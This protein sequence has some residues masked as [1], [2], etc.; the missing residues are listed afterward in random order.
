MEKRIDNISKIY[1]NGIQMVKNTVIFSILVFFVNT[2]SLPGQ[3]ILTGFVK[4]AETGKGLP[5]ANIQIEGT[6]KGTITN[7][8]GMFTL[9]IDELP[10]TLLITYIGYVPRRILCTVENSNE[11]I[12]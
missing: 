10:V 11:W 2:A 4:D 1:S 12:Q 5:I 8:D 6:Y 3:E 7:D 9:K